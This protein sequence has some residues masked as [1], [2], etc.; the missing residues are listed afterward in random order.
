[1]YTISSPQRLVMA[2]VKSEILS[3]NDSISEE[4]MPTEPS[5]FSFWVA[6]NLPLE[7]GLKLHLLKLDNAVQRLRCEL[8][9]ME[10]VRVELSRE[11]TN[12]IVQKIKIVVT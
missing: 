5:A 6:G 2:K 12:D 11:Y 3:W 1:M 7:D 10:R 4:H 9:I 8:S